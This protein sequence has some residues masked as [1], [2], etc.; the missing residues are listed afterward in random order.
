[1]LGSLVLLACDSSSNEENPDGSGGA[2]ASGGAGNATS[3]GASGSGASGGSAGASGGTSGSGSGAGGSSGSGGSTSGA[4]GSAAAAAGFS[5]S[6]GGEGYHGLRGTL[7]G[8][9]VDLRYPD[10]NRFVLRAGDAFVLSP[11]LGDSDSLYYM[12]GTG[13]NETGD[14]R[15]AHVLFKMPAAGPHADVFFCAGADSIF[16]PGANGDTF[17]LK[18]LSRL[19]KCSEHTGTDE[20]V[21]DVSQRSL[22]GTA[23]GMPW[24]RAIG[25][26]SATQVRP[27][28]EYKFTFASAPISGGTIADYPYGWVAFRS[29]ESATVNNEVTLIEPYVFDTQGGAPFV[30]CGGAA[31]TAV[32]QN[33]ETGTLVA[34]LVGGAP[35]PACPGTPVDGE[36]SAYV[37]QFWMN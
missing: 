5:G 15:L 25:G 17:I 14:N 9:A 6:G 35:L 23:A 10:S 8:A 22:A 32:G 31:A 29:A 21:L 4:G 19:G 27:L 37:E 3:G 11:G 33:G 12:A 20:L 24:S 7:D 26:F 28:F 34:D 30:E 18:N 1:M 13:L 36:L 16:R 2:G